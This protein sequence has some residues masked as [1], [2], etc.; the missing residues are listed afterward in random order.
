V[1]A[2]D[3]N[4]QL[5]KM[6]HRLNRMDE[7]FADMRIA[8]NDVAEFKGKGTPTKKE[9]TEKLLYEEAFSELTQK[10][11]KTA[12]Q[13]FHRYIQKYPK[14]S[15]A[16]NAQYWKGECFFALGDFEKAILEF[17]KVIKRYPR[18]NK[19]P[20]AILKQG[21]AFVQLKAY[22]DAKAFFELLIAEY[23]KTQEAFQAKE[24]IAEVEQLMAE[25]AKENP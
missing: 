14:S 23:P 25:A 4:Q 9:K 7:R 18:G 24:K 22:A 1:D 13:L 11:Y 21:Y 2:K 17:Q 8:V 6:D 3:R 10:N 15:L 12:S 16:D 5:Q 19:V 20:A